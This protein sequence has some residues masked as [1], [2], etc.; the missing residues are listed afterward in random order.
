MNFGERIKKEILSKPIKDTHCRKAFVA[1]M[2]RG[3]GRLYEKDGYLGLEFS[4]SDEETA[5]FMTTAFRSLFGYEMRE[6]SVGEDRLNKKDKFTFNVSGERTE[7]ILKSL[8]ILVE[9]GVDLA[10]NLKLYGELTKKECCLHAFIRGLFVAVGGC[11]LPTDNRSSSTGYHLEMV[12]SHYTP[13]LETSEKLAA[14]GINS[15]ITRR[16]ESFVLYIKSA[17]GI[18]DF[19]AFLPA[20]V[21]V[22]KLTELMINREIVNYSNR[23]KNCDIANVNKQVEASAKQLDAIEKIDKAVGLSSLKEDLRLTA[24]ARKENSDMTLV[25]LAE[26]LGVTK[27]CL[28]HRLRKLIQI[29]KEI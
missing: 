22:L 21:S 7:E 25:E 12:F 10:V 17:E 29:S 14:L 15:R 20:P 3:S 6:V 1:G 11:T 4:V 28:N 2:I 9:D 26:H 23:Q 19:V 8:E 16:R 5:M 24:V 27:S 18:K 13:A